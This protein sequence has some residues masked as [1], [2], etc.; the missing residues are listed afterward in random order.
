MI[1]EQ[2]KGEVKQAMLAKDQ[3]KLAVVRG[4]LSAFTNELVN[5]KR[6]PDE[7]LD[8]ETAIAVIRRESK[9]RKDSISQF[10]TGGR[11]DLAEGEKAELALIEVYLPKLMSREEIKPLAEAK[12]AELGISGKADAGKL[13]NALMKDLKGKADGADVKAV[14]DEILS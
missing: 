8:D 7:M 4:L 14:A 6:K 11:A 10:E 9:K 3:V 2:I 13:M 1:H 5:Q 12:K